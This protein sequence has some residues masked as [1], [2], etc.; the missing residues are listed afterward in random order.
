MMWANVVNALIGLWFAIAPFVLHYQEPTVAM[1]TSIVGGLI[2]LVLA[3]W[4]VFDESARKQ[5]WI[6]YVNGLVGIWFIIFPFAFGFTGLLNILW[7]S[8]I[9]GALALV[10]SAWLAFGVLAKEAPT[11]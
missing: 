5:K 10:L 3:G 4:A 11:R 6:Q 8:L 9:G 7:T 1:W 2:L